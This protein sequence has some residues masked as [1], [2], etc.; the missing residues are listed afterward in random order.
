MPDRAVARRTKRK[1]E[2]VIPIVECPPELSPAARKNGI[3]SLQN[4][5][6]LVA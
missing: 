1:D 5:P 4:S 3:E 6:P 2:P